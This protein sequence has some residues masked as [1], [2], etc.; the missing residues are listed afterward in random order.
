M[1]GRERRMSITSSV[2]LAQ[3]SQ[4]WIARLSSWTVWIA[5]FLTLSFGDDAFWPK[6]TVCVCLEEE[7]VTVVKAYRLF[8][9]ITV[10][11]VQTFSGDKG[12]EAC[13]AQVG[14]ALYDLGKSRNRVTLF[15]PRSWVITRTIELPGAVKDA[16]ARAVE[17]EFDRLT[18]LSPGDA[19]FD[20][21]VVE[22]TEEKITLFLAAS[23]ADVVTAY[24]TAFREK[25]IIVDR[26]TALLSRSPDY[27]GVVR[28]K[29]TLT[30]SIRQ[31]VIDSLWPKAQDLDLLARGKRRTARPPWL[32]TI[33]LLLA[34]SAAA[35]ASAV[36][37]LNIE[38]RRIAEIDRQIKTLKEP[39]RKVEQIKK[40]IVLRE[41]EIATIEGFKRNRVRSIDLLKEITKVLPKTSYL[42]RVRMT[43]T[44]VDL[45]GYAGS[46][47]EILPKLEASPLLKKVE[48]A[49][50]TFRDTRLNADRFVIKAEIEND[51]VK[52]E[53]KK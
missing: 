30:P 17:F 51:K 37:P 26:V 53:T 10:N 52:G 23:R 40:E 9:R 29:A 6:R 41:K 11:G 12:A 1:P 20:Y 36:L 49:S 31:S 13:A 3:T 32:L 45:E 43:D 42:T 2:R 27:P 21:S 50:P 25:G 28:S 33:L 18:P 47:A 5:R 15:I 14:R 24:T 19:L 22:S 46:A 8:F 39:V 44:T 4:V 16:L 38:E 7:G 48:F 34:I 35:V